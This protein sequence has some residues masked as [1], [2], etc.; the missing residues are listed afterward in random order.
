MPVVA[1]T[2][3]LADT[4]I[5]ANIAALQA[6]ASTGLQFVPIDGP[7]LRHALRRA[8]ALFREP[9]TWAALQRNGMRADVSWDRSAA[10]YAA[11]Y[12]SLLPS[13]DLPE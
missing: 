12:A 13:Q 10:E 5:D 3:G 4:V 2:G 7:S 11:L 9:K 8:V 6:G 1:R